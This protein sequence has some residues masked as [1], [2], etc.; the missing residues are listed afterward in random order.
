MHIADTR[1]QRQLS[2]VKDQC[3]SYD[4]HSLPIYIHAGTVSYCCQSEGSIALASRTL[5][6]KIQNLMRCLKISSFI[7]IQLVVCL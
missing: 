2:E 1:K 7:I 6:H 3:R 4:F 5:T